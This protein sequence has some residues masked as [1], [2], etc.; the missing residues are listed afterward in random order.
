MSIFSLEYRGGKSQ[1]IAQRYEMS[2]HHHEQTIKVKESHSRTV[3][4]AAVV[5]EVLVKVC[6]QCQDRCRI[7]EMQQLMLKPWAVQRT[8]TS[9][10]AEAGLDSATTLRTYT[11]MAYVWNTSILSK[12]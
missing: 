7:E 3:S 1:E 4:S 12:C 6:T 10:I 9:G 2:K 11:M 5:F 8:I